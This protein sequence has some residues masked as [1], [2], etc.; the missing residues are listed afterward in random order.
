M[1]AA[2]RGFAASGEK[3][4][5][6]ADLVYG[7]R[8]WD[9]RRR[10][11]ARLEHGPAK[12]KKGGANPRF[13]VTSLKGGGWRLYDEVYYQRGEMENRFKVRKERDASGAA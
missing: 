2:E 6:F 3:Q 10:V 12:G 9:R 1:A 5:R 11:I 8:T 7:A 4:R 13:V